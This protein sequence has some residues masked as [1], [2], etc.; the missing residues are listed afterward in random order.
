MEHFA[1]FGELLKAARPVIAVED[2]KET[3][4]ANLLR[5]PLP[6]EPRIEMVTDL[7]TVCTISFSY[8]G[9]VFSFDAYPEGRWHDVPAVM[10]GFDDFMLAIGREDRCYEL[11]GGGEFGLFVVAPAPKFEPIASRLLIPLERDS[12]SARDAAKAYQRQIQNM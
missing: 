6:Q 2:L 10:K 12:A 11:Q 8:R 7:G 9:Q 5:E 3:I 4:N 1:L